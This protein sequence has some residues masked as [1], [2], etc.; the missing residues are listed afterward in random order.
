M[1]CE[2]T[3]TSVAR[4]VPENDIALDTWLVELQAVA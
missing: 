2:A 4:D 1:F 3:M